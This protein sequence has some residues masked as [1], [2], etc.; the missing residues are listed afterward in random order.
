MQSR[1]DRIAPRYD[2]SEALMERLG[3]ARWRRRLWK[4]VDGSVLEVGVGT[5]KNMDCYL[6]VARPRP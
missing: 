6:I 5:G 1:Y 2:R 4:H 3:F